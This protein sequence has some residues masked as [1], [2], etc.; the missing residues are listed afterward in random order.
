M[1]RLSRLS[2]PTALKIAG[3][4]ALVGACQALIISIPAVMGGAAAIQ[5]AGN[6]PP[7]FVFVLGLML[8]PL[9]IAG[10]VGAWRNERWGVVVLLF[11]A[12]V[13]LISAAPGI[14]FAPAPLLRLF[15]A[16]AVLLDMLI[17]ALCLWP[18]Q[19]SVTT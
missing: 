12:S 16:Y 19:P 6:T 5:H 9:Q 13:D 15:S 17:I 3:A 8:A 1:R 11:T 4:I 7:F 14:L 2:R 10:A 18:K